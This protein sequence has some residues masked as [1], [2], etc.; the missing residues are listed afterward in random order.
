M[1]DQVVVLLSPEYSRSV[2]WNH[3]D[4]DTDSVDLDGDT[5]GV[6]L[7]VSEVTEA[8]EQEENAM[9][10]PGFQ[11]LIPFVVGNSVPDSSKMHSRHISHNI[12]PPDCPIDPAALVP[13]LL[14]GETAQGLLTVVFIPRQIYTEEFCRRSCNKMSLKHLL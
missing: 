7:F 6:G 14:P 4:S 1:C 9:P 12:I 13:R 8:N 10:Y 11:V 2:V 3:E 5:D